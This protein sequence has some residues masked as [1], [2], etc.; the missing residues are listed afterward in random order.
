MEFKIDIDFEYDYTLLSTII[1]K[2]L[3]FLEIITKKC[4][5]IDYS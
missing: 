3:K 2:T 4:L 1:L 5:I